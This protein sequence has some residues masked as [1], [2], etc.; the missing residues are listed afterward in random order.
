MIVNNIKNK[1][2][3]QEQVKH[4]LLLFLCLLNRLKSWK[5]ILRVSNVWVGYDRNTLANGDSWRVWVCRLEKHNKSSKRKEDVPV[6]KRRKTMIR[7]AGLCNARIKV[8]HLASIKKA[9][10]WEI[11]AC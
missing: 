6:E 5:T 11:S 1:I 8:T 9:C 7:E 10:I 3:N 4:L 2:F